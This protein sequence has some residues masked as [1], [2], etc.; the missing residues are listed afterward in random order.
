MNSAGIERFI[1]AQKKSWP[2][3]TANYNGLRDIAVR[4]LQLDGY[5]FR[6]QF[7]P[8]RAVSTG[9]RI[10]AAA[11]ASRPCFL[12]A[13]NR[14]AAQGAFPGPDGFE[15]LLNPFPIFEKHLTIPSLRHTPQTIAGNLDAMLELAAS[16]D[17]FT[18]F[19]NGPRCGASAPDHMHFQAV[20]SRNLPLWEWAKP[21]ETSGVRRLR[22]PFG[23]ILIET[24]KADEA[25]QLAEEV[26][27]RLHVQP[28]EYEPRVNVLA[29]CDGDIYRVAVIPRR[30]H[31][32]GCYSATDESGYM[33]SPASI[34]LAGVVVTPRLTDFQ[35]IDAEKLKEIINE[36]TGYES[37]AT[38]G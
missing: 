13:R 34:D 22:E 3:A 20:E 32:P 11:I 24:P 19:Y 10:D 7:N 25:R 35:R 26:L 23:Y 15:I 36:V 9:A 30:A 18:V 28:E 16:L 12:C 21:A 27:D 6:M 29:R 31:R 4:E 37:R 2:M 14:D 8:A 38:Q 17:G 1:E 5:T 33:I